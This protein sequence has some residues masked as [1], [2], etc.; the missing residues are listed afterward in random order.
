[1]PLPVSMPSVWTASQSPLC[2]FL[3]S[4]KFSVRLV[5][6]FIIQ[7]CLCFFP[8]EF[9]KFCY[10]PDPRECVKTHLS[11]PEYT[12]SVFSSLQLG[13]HLPRKLLGRVT[14]KTSILPNLMVSFHLSSG[15][16]KW[17]FSS[18]WCIS[19]LVFQDS[20]PFLFISEWMT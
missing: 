20:L 15:W 8:S 18:C 12:R 7:L 16:Q 17:S 6:V 9:I 14:S 5:H 2:F 10:I 1:M 19:F 13:F 11:C 4:L 3:N